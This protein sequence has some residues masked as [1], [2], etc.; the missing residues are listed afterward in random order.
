MSVQLKSRLITAAEFAEYPEDCRLDLIKGELAPMPPMPDLSHG[1]TTSVLTIYAGLHVLTQ[2]L[3]RCYAAETRFV[4][5]QGPDTAIAPDWA[6]I[7][8][9]RLPDVYPVRGYAAIVP[10]LVLEVRSS[11]DTKA[12]AEAKMKQWIQAG[13]LLG[14]ELNMKTRVMTVYR[15]NQET[16]TIDVDGTIDGEDVLPGFT[17]P[18]RSLFG[19]QIP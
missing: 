12:E 9:D 8:K 3:G 13:V 14:W 1:D 19:P 11:S 2:K 15:P 17:L 5:E 10:D 4:I 7:A 18:M 6:F 16:R